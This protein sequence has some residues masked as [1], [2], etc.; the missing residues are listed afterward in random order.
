VS[1]TLIRVSLLVAAHFVAGSAQATSY[2]V[3]C[4]PTR[5]GDLVAA[6]ASANATAEDD[7]IL[8]TTPGCT[9][10]L[11]ALDNVTDG[12]N[13]LPVVASAASAGRLTIEGSSATLARDGDAASFRLLLIAAGGDLTLRGLTLTGGED[14]TVADDE[15]AIDPDEVAVAARENEACRDSA[16]GEG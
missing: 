9:Y 13:G 8:L 12:G 2:E 4:G 3:G 11:T 16:T 1:R 7:R 14:S 6:I 15:H 5:V 10:T